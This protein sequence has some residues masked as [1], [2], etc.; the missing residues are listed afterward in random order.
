MC[1]C[2]L[3]YA[4]AP[5]LRS[6]YTIVTAQGVGCRAALLRVRDL[7]LRFALSVPNLD[8]DKYQSHLPGSYRD[9]PQSSDC[10]NLLTHAV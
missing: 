2:L 8:M 1:A 3:F 4:Q 6:L 5:V 7:D 9:S 10:R